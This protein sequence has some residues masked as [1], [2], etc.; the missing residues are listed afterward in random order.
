MYLNVEPEGNSRNIFSSL[1]TTFSVDFCWC[2]N[3]LI[4]VL[5]Q[6]TVHPW[7][8]RFTL[9]VV[10]RTWS[11][12]DSCLQPAWAGRAMVM[13]AALLAFKDTYEW[14]GQGHRG[15]ICWNQKVFLA[16]LAP[17]L[18]QMTGGWAIG[19]TKSQFP[20]ME[21]LQVVRD[22]KDLARC[23]YPSFLVSLHFSLFLLL[24]FRHFV[25]ALN[26]TDAEKGEINILMAMLLR[27]F[28]FF[29][30]RNQQRCISLQVL[31]IITVLLS[32]YFF[33]PR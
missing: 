13:A 14:L 1:L 28:R 31:K 10:K 8:G 20:W 3:S 30:F 32:E 21:T 26:L 25:S 33:L 11:K 29:N 9:P 5:E 22:C 12:M 19:Q 16:N 15:G 4:F 27:Y 24:V 17:C 2:R 18:P 23:R 6:Q 7:G